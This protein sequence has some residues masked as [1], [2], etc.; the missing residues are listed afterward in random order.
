MLA[1][2]EKTMSDSEAKKLG[3]LPLR[4]V[5]GLSGQA[6]KIAQQLDVSKLD[7]ADGTDYLIEKISSELRPRRMQQARELYEAGAQQGGMLSRQ[8]GESM[9]Q[10]ILRRKAWYR[11]MTD[12]SSDLK[13]P[14]IVL[15]EQLLLNSGHSKGYKQKPRY[16]SAFHADGQ[17]EENYFPETNDDQHHLD[18]SDFLNDETDGNNENPVYF[19]DAEIGT[20]AEEHL[21]YLADGG[22]DMEDP[23]ACEFASDLIQSEQDAYFARKGA[24]QK[25]HGGFAKNNAP[26]FE[27]SGS[28]SLDD[29]RARLRALKARTTCKRC[30]AVGHWS[31][32]YECPMSKG[33]SKK[34]GGK[35]S[36]S[37]STSS[38]TG[39]SQY[40][41][42]KG[43]PGKPSR[44]RTVYFSISETTASHPTANLA[45]RREH[46]AALQ[47]TPPQG[48]P[49]Q[50]QWLPMETDDPEMQEIMDALAM[51]SLAP[52]PAREN[53][54]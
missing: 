17:D 37:I 42:G 2:K 54:S 3:S 29:K 38:T 27:I 50:G 10:Y 8:H 16:Y 12:L 52:E 20:Y 22:L 11:A 30:G 40:S 21:A 14:D 36:T 51:D 19:S 4:L 31:G 13:L 15:S 41:G 28:I 49:E 7:T 35:A 24:Q 9:S 25:G 32:D 45:Y 39:T 44:P 46:A 18:T 48:S 33:K 23:E 1:Q 26:P 53:E 34:G 43:R 47:N 6:L 5:E